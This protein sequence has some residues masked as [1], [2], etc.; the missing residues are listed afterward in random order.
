M[1]RSLTYE[2]GSQAGMSMDD[3]AGIARDVERL[4]AGPSRYVLDQ[5]HPVVTPATKRGKTGPAGIRRLR[6]EL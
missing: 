3:L 2:T 1:K 4:L 6:L 5:L